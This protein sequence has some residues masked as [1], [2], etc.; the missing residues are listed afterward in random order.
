MLTIC[1]HT[2]QLCDC[3]Q[4]CNCIYAVFL[5]RPDKVRWP[6]ILPSI[7]KLVLNVCF[8]YF[9]TLSTK[10]CFFGTTGDPTTVLKYLCVE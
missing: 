9:I 4:V 8:F 6:Q 5:C 10:R 7:Y 3:V 2:Q 1:L